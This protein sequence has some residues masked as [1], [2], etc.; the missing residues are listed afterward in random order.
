MI[1]VFLTSEGEDCDTCKLFDTGRHNSHRNKGFVI[2]LLGGSDRNNFLSL[3]G[4]CKGMD[5]YE[6]RK[7]IQEMLVVV[8]GVES[9]IL[10]LLK[11]MIMRNINSDMPLLYKHLEEGG[12]CGYHLPK[13]DDISAN[14][15]FSL[16]VT[17][18]NSIADFLMVIPVLWCGC[19]V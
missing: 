9:R 15:L 4:S 17:L 3:P 11:D 5:F 8:N 18:P 19:G 10:A 7:E 1:G 13:G 2:L 14:T 12:A 16:V 6:G